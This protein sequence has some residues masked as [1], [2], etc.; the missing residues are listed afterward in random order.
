MIIFKKIK[1]FINKDYLHFN[2]ISNIIHYLKIYIRFLYCINIL[3]CSRDF[4][5]N[6]FIANNFYQNSYSN[7]Y[8]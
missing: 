8:I 4:Y 6:D 1:I 7:L 5:Y 2:F 3:R